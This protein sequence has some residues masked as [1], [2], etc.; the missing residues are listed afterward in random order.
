MMEEPTFILAEQCI[1]KPF[2][3]GLMR[4]CAPFSCGQGQI[5]QDLNDFFANDSFLYKEELLG[6][7]YCWVTKE[8]PRRIVGLFTISNDSIKTTYLERSTSNRLNRHINNA[9]EAAAIL[10]F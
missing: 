4:M 9:K 1:M 7:T 5:E 3:K 6:K 8:L 2:T 10:P